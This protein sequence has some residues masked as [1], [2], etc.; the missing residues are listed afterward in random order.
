MT[1]PTTGINLTNLI[2]NYLPQTTTS[3]ELKA[4]FQSVGRLESCRL[5][6]DKTTQQSLCYGFINYDNEDDAERAIKTFN[7]LNLQNKIIKVSY[8]R[9]SSESIKGANLY[10]CGLPKT[11]TC[12]EM[13]KYFG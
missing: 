7:G 4:I 3:D 2:V 5:I 12:E 9:P 8:A 1:K 10:V 13:N 6:K 11:W